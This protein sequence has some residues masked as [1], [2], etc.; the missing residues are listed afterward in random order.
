MNTIAIVVTGNKQR[1]ACAYSPDAP[2]VVTKA[3]RGS[4]YAIT[5]VASGRSVWHFAKLATA[6][7]ACIELL[8]GEGF[9]GWQRETE[10]LMAD[11]DLAVRV[12]ITCNAYDE[13][14]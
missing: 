10:A 3:H 4:K 1:R 2:L 11:R 13:A 8:A 7:R 12:R 6:R 9:E 5:H 14:T